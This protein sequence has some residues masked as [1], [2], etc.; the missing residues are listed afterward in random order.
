MVHQ[1]STAAPLFLIEDFGLC[2][3][4]IKGLP[5]FLEKIETYC[6]VIIMHT[7]FVCVYMHA[8]L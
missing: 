2:T 1:A 8:L 5:Y 7:F 3:C 4:I 6:F